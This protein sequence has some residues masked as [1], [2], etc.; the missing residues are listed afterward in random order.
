MSWLG[1]KKEKEKYWKTT[2]IPTKQTTEQKDDYQA[3]LRN[4]FVDATVSV[5]CHWQENCY[6]PRMPYYYVWLNNCLTELDKLN[7]N[8]FT[9]HNVSKI[10][11]N[12]VDK[13][14]IFSQIIRSGANMPFASFSS[15]VIDDA[16][17]NSFL[18]NK[19]FTSIYDKLL[20]TFNNCKKLREQGLALQQKYNDSSNN[21]VNEKSKE[22][23]NDLP[24][25]EKLQL[26]SQQAAK[27]HFN[28]AFKQA[29][30]S[31]LIEQ[32]QSGSYVLQLNTDTMYWC[33]V[34][35]N[36]DKENSKVINNTLKLLF[37]LYGNDFQPFALSMNDFLHDIQM[38]QF[39]MLLKVFA[40]KEKIA[41]KT[42][43][44]IIELNWNPS[45][46]LQD[47][48]KL[49]NQLFQEEKLK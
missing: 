34:L 10:V 46:S 23:Y 30:E 39:A 1:S 35:S 13:D 19:Y 41:L 9:K 48:V 37:C 18:T 29:L 43:D 7:D 45:L 26:M 22:N 6:S 40:I 14:V 31:M 20:L 24:L 28:K 44:S 49:S 42:S 5:L 32:A 33:N 11:L 2:N 36:K 3:K 38:K 25:K 21:T 16:L 17:I 4:G 8:S 27:I 47:A 12:N 15:V